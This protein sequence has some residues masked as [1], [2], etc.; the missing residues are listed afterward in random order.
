MLTESFQSIATATR[1]LLRNWRFMIVLAGLYASLIAALYLFVT[2]REASM[3]QVILS[4]VLA[5]TAPF[6]FFVL[7]TAGASQT[8]S[9]SAGLLLREALRNSWKVI[10][11]SVPLVALTVLVAYL[12]G[13]AQSYTGTDGR[14]LPDV[15]AQYQ[16]RGS[17]DGRPALRWS[18]VTLNAIRYLALG[19]VLPLVAI[20]LW[21]ASVGRDLVVTIRST[22]DLVVQAF[23]PHSVLIYTAG[24]VVFGVIPYLLLFK[25]TP[26]SRAWMEIT[27]FV[28]RLLFGFVLTLFGWIVTMRALA[29]SASERPG[30]IRTVSVSNRS[31]AC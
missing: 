31:V 6:L 27:F 28:V 19:L 2:M 5:I 18:Q 1:Q 13:K 26:A 14:E 4:L 17:N 8:R 20:H 21:I 3:G 12:L 23:A 7:Q 15:A 10:A 11:I 29:I 9:L 25:P 30:P 22:K 16:L 24:F